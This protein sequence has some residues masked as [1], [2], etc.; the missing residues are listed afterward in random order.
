VYVIDVLD[1]MFIPP[2]APPPP[3]QRA[4]WELAA[5]ASTFGVSGAAP[6]TGWQVLAREHVAGSLG[7][8]FGGAAA[9][10]VGQAG[11]WRRIL[12]AHAGGFL[13]AGG[14]ELS[15][16]MAYTDVARSSL[17]GAP[18]RYGELFGYW[19]HRGG[20]LEL[21]VG[22]GARASAIG[23][24][25]TSGWGSASA[26]L[27]VVPR[28]AV[29]V[30]A[31][32]AL[33]DVARAVPSVRYVSLALR[34]GLSRHTS[35]AVISVARPIADEDGAGRLDVRATSDSM[36]LIAIHLEHAGAVEL[37]A[38]FTDWEPAAMT[39]APNGAWT[40]ERPITPG[41][42]HV[43]IRVDGGPWFAPA[44]LTRVADEFGGEVGLLIVP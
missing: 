3:F 17:G 20:P 15:A 31:G 26:A 30:S 38:D 40:M 24:L 39:K 29:V 5:T 9:G 6:S 44:N 32:R 2:G 12:G 28:A 1:F 43:A 21:L 8:G 18:L 10:M 35:P 25:G 4:R 7:G 27:W 22:G 34:V 41:V 19:Q 42:H 16:V 14:D 11:S 23:P 13:H 37:M 36:R 33:E